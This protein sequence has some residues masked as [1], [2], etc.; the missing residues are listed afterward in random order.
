MYVN[1]RFYRL[2]QISHRLQKKKFKADFE[3]QHAL[4]F[5]VPQDPR[6]SGD[7]NTELQVRQRDGNVTAIQTP[8]D[9]TVV[10][11]SVVDWS[12]YRIIFLSVGLDGVQPHEVRI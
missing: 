4:A 9:A 6:T 12:K 7:V 2:S 3:R 11:T 5:P 1:V 8:V 10:Q